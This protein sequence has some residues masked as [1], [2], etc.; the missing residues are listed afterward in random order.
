MEFEP[1]ILDGDTKCATRHGWQPR[2]AIH[3]APSEP[4]SA[5][6]GLRTVFHHAESVGFELLLLLF[7]MEVSSNKPGTP[8]A[9]SG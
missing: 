5:H 1:V 6:V 7:L 2:R 3:D 9:P 8:Q 4:S